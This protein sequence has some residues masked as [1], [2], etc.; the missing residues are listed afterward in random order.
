MGVAA[1]FMVRQRDFKRMLAYSSV[2]HMGILVLG[3][4]L[5]GIGVF[6]ALLHAVNNGL[7]KGVLFLSAGNIHR[8]YG[9]KSTDEVS[10]AISRLPDLGEPL[11]RRLLRDHRLAAVRPVRQRVHDPERR[12]RR[13]APRRRALFL[14][15]LGIVFIGMGST[16]LSVVQGRPR[17]APRP[18]RRTRTTWPGPLPIL[19]AAALVLL[20]GLWLPAPLV[21][22][23]DEAVGGPGGAAV[24]RRPSS[25]ARATAA[26]LPL[27]TVPLADVRR[28]SAARSSASSPTAGGS[29][30][31]FA[32]PRAGRAAPRSGRSSPTTG[33]ATL[34]VARTRP[35]RTTASR[36]SRPTARRRTS[37]SGRSPS[38]S[39]CCPQ[40]HPW[41]K[42]VRFRPLVAA[43]PRRL[44]A[45]RGRADPAR[46]SA[47]SSASRGDEVHEVAVGPV[48]A[49]VIEPGHF[50]FQCHGEQVFHLEIALG[51][52]HR[53]VERVAPRRPHRQTTARIETLA[54]DTTIG[55]AT[56]YCQAVEALSARSA[57]PRA[58]A[59]RGI[60]L[61]LE[62]LANHAGDLGALAGD[63]GFLP[64]A[65]FCG[66]LRG[67]F[68][69]LTALLCGNRFGRGLVRPGGTLVDLDEAL[70]A[71]L[72]RRLE[73]TMKDLRGAAELLLGRADGHGAVRGHRAASTRRRP[74][75]SASSAPRRGPA[76]STRTCGATTRPGST[77][78]P[79]SP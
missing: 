35:R 34:G 61:E 24:T 62:R 70:A 42:P 33:P 69:N 12:H 48:H 55:H 23:L 75:R 40:G 20:L 36:R 37:S 65:S 68:L 54:G 76:A 26:A 50:R 53:G 17:D 64:T 71:E 28:A 16:V 9:S 21:S 52:Q 3:I 15:L 56:A 60:A 63:V 19:V 38:S 43:G 79:T 27:A 66:R 51:Y 49:G 31:F 45:D 18:G 74:S 4:G 6:G 11:P 41:L 39:A 25:A 5:G 47:T 73:E 7:T 22:L 46:P 67:D 44:G 59:L 13:R 58:Q 57:P 29:S 30:R 8:A 10:G 72:G 78:S 2:E 32:A 14:V 77:A 1:V